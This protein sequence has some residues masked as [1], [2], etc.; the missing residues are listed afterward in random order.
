MNANVSQVHKI[1]KSVL[2]KLEYIHFHTAPFLFRLVYISAN[3]PNLK[4]MSALYVLT[5]LNRSM[6][7]AKGIKNGFHCCDHVAMVFAE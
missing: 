7:M 2:F 6:R 1:V 3:L 5:I 4:S